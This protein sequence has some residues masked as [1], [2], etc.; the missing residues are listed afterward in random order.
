MNLSHRE[1]SS[2]QSDEVTMGLC[3]WNL[4]LAAAETRNAVKAYGAA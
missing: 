4:V 1:G 2:V 3:R